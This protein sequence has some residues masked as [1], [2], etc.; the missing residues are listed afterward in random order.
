METGD[1]IRR[2]LS[3]KTLKLTVSI[4]HIMY[5]VISTNAATGEGKTR[6]LQGT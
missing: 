1:G 3:D 5:L 2:I 6:I 4:Y